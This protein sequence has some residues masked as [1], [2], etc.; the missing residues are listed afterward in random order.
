MGVGGNFWDLLKPY[1][2]AEGFDFLR[3]K[4]VAVDL[5][6]WIVQQET[7]LKGHIRNPHIRL[8]FFRTINL[9][10]KF[11]AFLVFV[12]DGTA[13]P[14]KSQ[15]RIARFFWASGIDSSSLPVAEGGISIETNKAFQKCEKECVELLELLGVPVLKAK[16]EAE[17]LCAQLNREGLVDACITS[18]SGAFLFGAKCVIKNMQ[19]NS[20]EPFECYHMSDIESGLGLRRDQLIAISLLVGNDHNLTGVPGIGL[21][22]AVRFVKSFSDDEILYRLREIGGGDLRVFQ[23]VVNLD[24]SSIPSSDESPRKTKA[25]HCSFCGHPGSKKAHL[26]FACEYCSS[27]SNEG[28]IQKPLGFKCNCSSCDLDNKEKEQKRDEN[29]KIKVCRMIASEKNF[30]NKEITEMYLN[31]QHQYDGDYHLSWGNPKIDM[32]VDYLAYYQ[33]WEPSHTQQ[34]MLPML[35]TIFLRDV[36]SNSKDQLLCGQYEF[37]SIQ[38]VKTRFGHQLY[39]INW[40]KPTR[41]MSNEICIPSEDLDTEEE[42]GI[43]DESTDLLDEPD[44]LQ[45]HIKDG[46]S[47]LSTEEDMVLVQNAFP[48]KVSQFLRD[49]EL[50][51]T[52]SRRKRPVKS[53]NS[54][55]PKGVQLSISNFY[56]SSKA[57]CHEKPGESEAGCPKSRADTSGERD[58]EPIRNYSKSVRRKLLFD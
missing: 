36:A 17:A 25:R 41:E 53:D 42:T 20:N 49:K 44:A 37:D 43:A 6:Y 9:F 14:L 39:V 27:T 46:C 3:N 8:T 56:R 32:L 16:G 33:H 57:P 45:I 11:G 58:K 26:K 38:R 19:P 21:E 30:P 55:S 48:E 2:R 51:E 18:D 31:T 34:R 29:W 50:K 5:S 15:A 7:A 40:K 1:G 12:K 28:C 52:K 24:S 47:F 22:K 13:S 54:E 4:R 23:P 35:S 10:S